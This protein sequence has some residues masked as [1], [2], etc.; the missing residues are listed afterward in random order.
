MEHMGGAIPPTLYGRKLKHMGRASS[1]LYL[2]NS[3]IYYI[4]NVVDISFTVIFSEIVSG[5]LCIFIFL[6]GSMIGL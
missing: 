1:L 5:F 2:S 6:D 3:P 4:I